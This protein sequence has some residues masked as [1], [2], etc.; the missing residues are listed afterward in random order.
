M[1]I[2]VWQIKIKGRKNSQTS[3]CLVDKQTLETL[4]QNYKDSS[5]PIGQ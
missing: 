1:E 5:T 4:E 3:L 2:T